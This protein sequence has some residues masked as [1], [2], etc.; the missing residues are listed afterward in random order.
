MHQQPLAILP[1]HD[2]SSSVNGPDPIVNSHD[3][4]F[5]STA[6]DDLLTQA[7]LGPNPFW[8]TV[9]LVQPPTSVTATPVPQQ[10]QWR[11]NRLP[12]GGCIWAFAAVLAPL[13]VGTDSMYIQHTSWAASPQLTTMDHRTTTSSTRRSFT[14]ASLPTAVMADT[15]CTA[16]ANHALMRTNAADATKSGTSANSP[17]FDATAPTPTIP[18]SH[19]SIDSPNLYTQ[20]P[21]H[22]AVS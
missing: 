15:L 17:T 5:D 20:H 10:R 19:T 22:R 21:N 16:A 18:A 8:D 6:G 12:A 3:S 9:L 11:T 1:P 2:P 7:D 14:L 4:S 13:L